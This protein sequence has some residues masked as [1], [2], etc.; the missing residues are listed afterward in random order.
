MTPANL[1]KM[2]L[3]RLSIMTAKVSPAPLNAPLKIMEAAK[4]AWMKP[5]MKR[6]LA[7]SAAISGWFGSIHRARVW[8][9]E[10]KDD[11]GENHDA[12]ACCE[13]EVGAAAG[14]LRV[15]HSEG[16]AGEGGGGHRETEA[17]KIAHAF[18]LDGVDMG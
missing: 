13:G 9:E 2:M 7:V 17:G 1:R 4:A 12:S 14:A 16:L 3:A 11:A 5:A 6:Q 15:F 8:A 18:D 10:D